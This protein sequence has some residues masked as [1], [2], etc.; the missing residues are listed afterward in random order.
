MLQH[1]RT[2]A[3]EEDVKA[4]LAAKQFL[5]VELRNV[6]DRL[7]R[8]DS[9]LDEVKCSLTETVATGGE[10]GGGTTGEKATS[11]GN[12]GKEDPSWKARKKLKKK[13]TAPES[14]IPGKKA[15]KGC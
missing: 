14:Q 7:L 12:N 13:L 5:E 3:D 1:Y 15:K 10:A 4:L 11:R 8:V 2:Y 6:K 9:E